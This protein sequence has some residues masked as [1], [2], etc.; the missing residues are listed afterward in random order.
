V[1]EGRN[2]KYIE[3]RTRWENRTENLAGLEKM[4]KDERG[5]VPDEVIS[6]ALDN[7]VSAVANEQI[8][9][10]GTEASLKG[11]NP[12]QEREL[13][14]TARESLDRI[15][16]RMKEAE[17]AS[18]E[19]NA[20]LRING[21][22]GLYDKLSAA[23]TALMRAEY[24]NAS[25]VRRA[26]AVKLLYETMRQER[27][28]ARHAYVAPL[29]ERIEALGH[30]VFDDTLQI[31]VNDNLQI[32]SRTLQGRTLGFDSLSGGTKEQLSL[33]FRLACAMMVAK[34][35]GAP[36]ML[37]DALGYTDLD[38]LRLMGAILAKAAK[39]CQIVIFTCVPD[40]YSNIGA[41]KEIVMVK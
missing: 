16:E 12:E 6:T 41:A 20:R 25:L 30:L 8:N 1:Y 39:E 28:K 24:K 33:I 23:Q 21:E 35:G 9:V 31:E 32:V 7:A 37:D 13:D 4:L 5:I 34:D 15:R 26:S 10:N 17:R 29:R 22:D 11:L 2:N 3:E 40:R 18:I 27:D 14:K 38:R 36:V 19:V